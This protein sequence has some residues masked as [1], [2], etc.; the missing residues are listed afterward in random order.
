MKKTG[1]V[2]LV[3]SSFI[4]IHAD[5]SV[6]R[7]VAF[8]HAVIIDGTGE[9][10]IENGVLVVRG[11]KIEMV[12]PSAE[13]QIP[14]DA[15]VKDIGGKVI[16]PGLAD[17]HVHFSHGWDGKTTD[18]LGYQ[19]YLN[20]LLYS[21]ITTILDTGNALPF[22][23]QVRDE[24]AAG[25]LVGPRIYC[26]GPLIDG[27]DPMWPS[28]SYSL[29][30]V[31]QVA[32]VVGRLK[33]DRVDIIKAYSGLSDSIVAALVREASKNSLAL[34]VDQS[35]RNGS[36]ELVMG[37]GVTAFAHAPDFA[38]SSDAINMMKP[39]GVKFITTL[40]VVE[41]YSRRR[42]ADLAFL[43]SPL[44]KDTT[45]PAVLDALRA[46]ALRT[47]DGPLAASIKENTRRLR[48]RSSNVKTLFD[49]GF[50]LA[51][52]TDAPYPGVFQGEGLHRE[53]ELIV[54]AG[55]RPLDAITMATRNAARI[56]GGEGEWGT[57]EPGK[58]ANL[59]VINGRP[60]QRIQDARNIETVILQGRIIDRENLRLKRY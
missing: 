11:D 31:D 21:G 45:Q 44:I 47:P 40:A 52:G 4:F 51:A 24:I 27:A 59:L 58:L 53:L 1:F 55:L 34:F 33:R 12:G 35:W 43:E 32:R 37:D 50:L 17:M 42:L 46:E 22:I 54:E 36:L 26:A 20:A 3:L 13:I 5:S 49:A 10:P 57:L 48:M 18:L 29:T 56:I 23:I 7:P 9:A 19:G 28:I 8:T 6:Q 39:R 30:S 60:D 41:S 38:P 25:K 14:V 16:M 15:E 2:W